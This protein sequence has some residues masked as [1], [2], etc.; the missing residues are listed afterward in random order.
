MNHKEQIHELRSTVLG[1]LSRWAPNSEG[2]E[3]DQRMLRA[4]LHLNAYELD[5]K[6]SLEGLGPIRDDYPL[7][8]PK[9]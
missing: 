6:R 8:L 9:P 1:V 3:V 2:E 4:L 7:P 5:A